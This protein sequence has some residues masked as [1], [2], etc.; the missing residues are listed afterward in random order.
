MAAGGSI[1]VNSSFA[2][3]V[4]PPLYKYRAVFFNDEDLLSGLRRDPLAKNVFD[5]ATYSMLFET[6]LRLKGNAVIVA[7][8]PFPDEDCVALAHRR[9]LVVTHQHYTTLGINTNSWPLDFEDW[10]YRV[11][12]GAM[13][14]AWRASVAAQADKEVVWTVG[15]RGL[16]DYAY[17]CANATDCGSQISDVLGNQTAWVQAAQPGAPMI[18]F[19]WDELLD[20]LATGHLAIPPGVSVVFTDAGDGFIRVNDNVTRLAAGCYYHTAMFDG[21]ANQLTELVP[22]DRIIAQVGNF[23]AHANDTLVFILNLSDMLPVPMSSQAVMEMVWDPRPFTAGGDPGA[24]ALAYYAAW[25][26]RQLRLAPAAAAAFAGMWARYFNVSYL[27]GGLG[28]QF[29]P[30]SFATARALQ[31]VTWW[32]M[33]R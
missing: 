9:G 19:M 14:M 1:D 6:V 12:A 18:L 32:Q 21:F 3:L 26:T 27:Q 11:N 31:R 22:V 13:A 5:T 23:S 30:A 16:G 33:E 28:D 20:L 24:A 8:N 2:V 10:N 4:A 17:P 25:G 15:L 7:T 29:F